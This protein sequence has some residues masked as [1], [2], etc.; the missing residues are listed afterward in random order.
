MKNKLLLFLIILVGVMVLPFKVKATDYKSLNFTETLEAEEID[1]KYTSYKETDDQVTIYLF[2]GQGCSYCRGFLNFLNDNAEDLG[3]YFK[4]VSY[5]VWKDTNNAKLL[6]EVSEYLEQPA[7][8]VPYIVIG[9]QVFAGFTESA[10]GEKVKEA[11]TTLYKTDKSERYDVFEQMEKN[12]KNTNQKE[13][14]KKEKSS[15]N[16]AAI[17]LNLLFVTVGTIS[18]IV[19]NHFNFEKLSAQ[20]S[21]KSK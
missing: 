1:L 7:D 16:I 15:S 5:E 17:L 6:T 9:D 11:I 21:K 20:I 14:D 2:R 12:P 19:Y 13:S 4:V 8:G 10:Y 18:I 3:K